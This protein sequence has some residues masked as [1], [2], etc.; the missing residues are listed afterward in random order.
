MVILYY[1]SEEGKALRKYE[2]QAPVNAAK[3]KYEADPSNPEFV[4]EYISA[5]QDYLK[6]YDDQEYRIRLQELQNMR[7]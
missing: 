6:V 2:L 3:I 7:K 5:L 4:E 1:Q